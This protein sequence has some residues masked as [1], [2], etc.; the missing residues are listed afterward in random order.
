M[1]GFD[2]VLYVIYPLITYSICT[3]W[4]VKSL[5]MKQSRVELGLSIT[6]FTYIT[7]T[8]LTIFIP[9]PLGLLVFWVGTLPFTL[10]MTGFVLIMGGFVALVALYSP[11]DGWA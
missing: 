1:S 7:A 5:K 10:L 6:L 11:S 4:L 9:I 2:I 8:I 3:T